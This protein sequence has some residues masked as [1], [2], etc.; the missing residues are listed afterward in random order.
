MHQQRLSLFDETFVKGCIVRE[1]FYNSENNY[2]VCLFRVDESS[3]PLEE[4]EVTIVGYMGLPQENMSY[5]VYGHWQTHPRFGRQFYVERMV[6]ELPQSR[7]SVIKYLS[8]DLFPGIGPKTATYIVDQLGDNPLQQIM[9][10]PHKLSELPKLSRRRAE[11][12]TENLQKHADFEQVLLFLYECHIGYALALKIYQTYQRETI[13]VLRT[14]PYQLIYDIEGI[15]FAR[16]DAIGRA[17]GVTEEAPER[18]KAAIVYVLTQ[19]AH[20]DGHVFLPQGQ[21]AQDVAE[22][23][24]RSSDDE[25]WQSAFTTYVLEMSEEG[26]LVVDDDAVYLPSLYYSECGIAKKIQLLALQDKGEYAA[27]DIF[28]IVGELEEA[29]S[30]SFADAQREALLTA[31]A[32]PLMVLTGGPGTG[33]TTVI[34]GICHLLS[35]LEGFSLD[36][37]TD[38]E[39][40]PYPVR[41]VAPTGRA[42]KRMAEATGL[43]AMTIHRLLGW[44]GDFFE[45]DAEHPLTGRVLIVDEASM[46]DV[47]LA[48]QL[49]RA[50]PEGMKVIV[51]GDADQLPSVGPGQVF[52]HLI[53]SG[54]VPCIHLDHIY[55]QDEGSSIIELAHEVKAG[56][57]PPKLT[58]PTDDRRFLT[59]RK[60]EVAPLVVEL[61]HQA[62]KRGYTIFDVQVLAPMYRGPAGVDRLNRALQEVVNPKRKGSKE[63]AWGDNVFRLGDKMLQLTNNAE[64]S[65]YNGDIGEVIAIGAPGGSG[66]G[67]GKNGD[68][69]DICLWVRFDQTE[70]GYTRAQ[71]N[72]LSLAYCTSIH[73]A[74]GS[75]FPIVILPIVSA[76]RRMLQRN[77]VYTAIT[78]SKAYLML[79]GEVQAF[80]DGVKKVSG[81]DRNSRLG[82]R[83]Q[84]A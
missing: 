45:R 47:W 33:K 19:A 4:K 8:S 67:S 28:R 9:R 20:A 13:H 27:D 48:Y 31:A 30:L 36:Q 25:A 76:Y 66:G 17:A 63:V 44:R 80:A 62:L 38:S 53:Q 7:E 52:S 14:N 46:M 84:Q 74:Q 60:E 35:H 49:L 58:A 64:K 51:V 11:I 81:F 57:L 2:G 77:L 39:E 29:F 18:A 68:S 71:L 6:Q 32:Q 79:C 59:C 75:E 40:D 21:L 41:L 5:T 43:P 78:R 23:L 56:K 72:Q 55:R 65:V 10:Q 26:H 12:V 24:A 22:L 15:G 50:V 1:I 16:A 69:N 54:I 3:E 34:R 37:V 83:L 82:E 70:V 73:K 61:V 42:A